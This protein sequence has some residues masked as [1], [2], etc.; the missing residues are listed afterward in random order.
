M[1][2]PV[3]SVEKIVKLGLA[4]RNAV[5]K[6]RHNEVECNEIR[7]RVLRFSAILSQLQQTGMMDDSPGMSGA[8]EDL[9]ETLQNAL[10]LVTA[11]QEA[12]TIRQIVTAG[13]L[14]KKLRRVKDD[15]LNKVM[16]AS[17][18][19]H[20]HTTVVLLTIQAGGHPLPQQPEDERVADISHNSHSAEDPRSEMNGGENNVLT[21]S[22][23]SSTPSVDK[24]PFLLALYPYLV[25]PLEGLSELKAAIKGGDL[26]GK[27]GF[28]NVYKSV[29]NDGNVVAIKISNNDSRSSSWVPTYDQQL[30]LVPKL[31]HKNIVKVL[32]YC[33]EDCEVGSSSVIMRLLKRR[34]DQ[35][36]DRDGYIASEYFTEGILS[37]KN[38]VHGFGVILLEIVGSIYRS[39]P[40]DNANNIR[41]KPG[42]RKAWSACEAGRIEEL[43]DPLLF[44]GSQL[45]E[46]KRCTQVGL[47]C[48]PDDPADRPTMADVLE[49]LHGEKELPTPKRPAYIQSIVEAE[50]TVEGIP[51]RHIPLSACAIA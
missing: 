48:T 19:I 8:L 15:I 6:V 7:R 43:F 10:E 2:D 29:L 22:D 50:E 39:K 44:D 30:L 37:A 35:A 32:G 25:T 26:V 47:L 11:C 12:T 27:G 40:Y 1:A 9:E 20:A 14:S 18:A 31:Q 46:I 41:S 45:L 49:M 5:D 24:M 38:D 17:F 34:N 36:Q 21:G 33:R 28:W 42:V 4:I 13:E 3:A 23:P 16:L 51:G